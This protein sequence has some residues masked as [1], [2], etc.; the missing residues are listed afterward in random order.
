[1]TEEEQAALYEQLEAAGLAYDALAEDEKAALAEAYAQWSAMVAT[2]QQ[3]SDVALLAAHQCENG[4][5]AQPLS[6]DDLTAGTYYL[7]GDLTIESSIGISAG[8]GG[9]VRICLNGHS[10][11]QNGSQYVLEVESGKL[12]LCDCKGTGKV[13]HASGKKNTGVYVKSAGTF[14]MNSGNIVGNRKEG[15]S[16]GGIYNNGGT[17]EIN[18]GT[19][20][21]NSTDRDGGGIYNK[22]SLAINGGEIMNNRAEGSSYGG[23]IYNASGATLTTTNGSIHNNEATSGS[24]GG[25]ANEGTATIGD[26]SITNNSAGNKGGGIY[27]S[28]VLTLNGAT[29]KDN[30]ANGVGGGIWAGGTVTLHGSNEITY[31]SYDNL[32][33]PSGKYL[34][35][36]GAV[37]GTVYIDTQVDPVS[38][39]SV[40]FAKPGTGY[41]I[42]DTDVRAFES[43]TDGFVVK[44][45]SGGNLEHAVAA[46]PISAADFTYTAPSD[47]Y[48]TGTAK[49]AT[50]TAKQSATDAGVGALTISYYDANGMATPSRAG[51][52]T[53]K[54]TDANGVVTD[55]EVGE[56]T[57]SYITSLGDAT[58]NTP[59]GNNGWYIGDVTVTPPAGCQI[60]TVGGVADDGWLSEMKFAKNTNAAGKKVPYY[61]RD[62]AGHI[63]AKQETA[64]VKRD[65]AKPIFYTATSAT[66]ITETTAKIT[67]SAID[68]NPGSGIASYSLTVN[69]KT[70]TATDGVFNVTGLTAGT[71]YTATV[72]VTDNAGNV[73][74]EAESS[75]KSLTFTTKK[76]A[77]TTAAVTITVPV[78]NATPNTTA[79][80]AADA[81]YTVG[82]VTWA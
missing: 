63:T 78:K 18:G 36:G 44:K 53:V 29:I 41:T 70:M 69:G 39:T 73:G 40:E 4:T 68:A 52:Y 57:I 42:T 9:V 6:W 58:L 2:V 51:T 72:T 25:I 64:T 61:L 45:N 1:M 66:D 79:T 77:I 80:V 56:F 76:T 55:L 13:T 19:I 17:V 65:A 82:A 37:S 59:T 20:D 5:F 43:S 34:T 67:A 15:F 81:P 7:T 22:G 62:A 11:I 30:N 10:I 35:I 75:M 21:G 32:Y 74:T 54:I 27:N 16:G 49:A 48:Y 47:L 60:S 24:G 23:G 38:G 71:E 26:T 3:A 50:V 12:V 28:G 8:D 46:P 33:V 14:I 31:N